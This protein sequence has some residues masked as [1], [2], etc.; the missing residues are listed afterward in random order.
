MKR[1]TVCISVNEP[2][3]VAVLE[4]WFSKWREALTFV[5]EN[6]GCGCCVD[7]YRIE[8]PDHAIAELP[9]KVIATD[10]TWT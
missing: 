8:G 5:S 6:E 2:D 7:M 4:A 9:G 1:A 10:P 3:E